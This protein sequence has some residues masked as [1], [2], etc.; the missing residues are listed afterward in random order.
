MSRRSRCGNRL[1]LQPWLACQSDKAEPQTAANT[2]SSATSIITNP[3]WVVSSL[4]TVQTSN[5]EPGLPGSRRITKKLGMLETA[6]RLY[7]SDGLAG[8]FRGLGPAL[9][10]VINPIIVSF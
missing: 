3:I 4:Q 10:L 7:E 2:K 6:R 1:E 5:D 9:I 8:F